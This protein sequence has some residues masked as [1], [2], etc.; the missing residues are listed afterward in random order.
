MKQ[1]EKY[2]CDFCGKEICKSATET[3]LPVI[4]SVPTDNYCFTEVVHFRSYDICGD[5]L[6]KAT[7]IRVGLFGSNPRIEEK[8]NDT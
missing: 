5:C 7:N 2:F 1:P 6:K 8:R 4:E 3:T